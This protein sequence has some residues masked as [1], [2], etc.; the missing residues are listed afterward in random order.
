MLLYQSDQ[1]I[2]FTHVLK[3]CGIQRNTKICS[4]IHL[5]FFKS[6]DITGKYCR[7]ATQLEKYF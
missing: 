7:V 4:N 2:F 3:A 1:N 5:Y 6:H